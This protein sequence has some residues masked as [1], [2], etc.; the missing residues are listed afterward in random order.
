MT[1]RFLLALAVAAA[2]IGCTPARAEEAFAT[3]ARMGRGINILGFDGIWDG[4]TDAPFKRAYFRLIRNAGFSHVRINLHAFKYM[5]ENHVVSPFVLGRLDWV[6]EEVVAAGLV[7]VLDQ[8]N[9]TE[10]QRDPDLCRV[11]LTAFWEQV[12]VRYAGRQPSLVFEILNEPGGNMSTAQWNG[13]ANSILR[14][15][16]ATNPGR[17]VIVAALNLDDVN[18]VEELELP[19]DDRNI[20]VTIHYYKP[21]RFTHQGAVWNEEFGKKR[22]V[23]WGSAADRA[24][25]AADLDRVASWAARVRRPI[26]LGEFGVYEAADARSRVAYLSFVTRQAERHGWPW[27]V[28]QFSHDFAIF[29]MDG[30]RWNRDLL[31][32]LVPPRSHGREGAQG[33]PRI[34]R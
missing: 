26:Y 24:A 4:G 15:I 2:V 30:G 7:P 8:H 31:D 19:E 12:A 16:R 11:K 17:T 29:D 6:I 22:G 27:A 32:A 10:C 14:L 28:W 18:T 3:A 20:I 5:D 1:V 33:A 21:M 23:K 13:L 25:L 9:F 34:P